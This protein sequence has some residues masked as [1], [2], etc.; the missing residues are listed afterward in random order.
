[1]K[2]VVCSLLSLAVL[3]LLQ[4]RTSGANPQR[5]APPVPPFSRVTGAFFALS[6]ADIDASAKWYAEKLG[7]TVDMRSKS[8]K[9]SVVVLSGNGLT[10]EL[11]CHDD[12]TDLGK[13]AE[14]THGFV[15]AGLVV[16]NLG[17]TLVQLKACNVPIAYG[18]YA[19]KPGAP[20]NFIIRD[21]SGNL[22][23]FFGH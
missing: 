9:V 5:S 6:V 21:N 7:L 16:D 19:T 13:D 3:A 10:V 2:K 12:A 20:A 15:K 1:M 23:Q 18:P 17:K 11:L 14:L 22:I 4:T 8:G